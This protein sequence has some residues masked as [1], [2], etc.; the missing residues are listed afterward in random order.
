MIVAANPS[1]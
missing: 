1:G